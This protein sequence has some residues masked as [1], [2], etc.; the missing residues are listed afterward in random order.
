MSQPSHADIQKI[1]ALQVKFQA[2]TYTSKTDFVTVSTNKIC[3]E[4]SSASLEI[5]WEDFLK[6][7]QANGVSEEFQQ[8]LVT[9]AKLPKEHL[10]Q[11]ITIVHNY[12]DKSAAA[13]IRS[14][15]ADVNAGAKQLGIKTVELK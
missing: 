4:E 3:T 13:N 2:K 10:D 15:T 5:D 8:S 11:I 6:R 7:C 14:Y 12:A 9:L 1:K